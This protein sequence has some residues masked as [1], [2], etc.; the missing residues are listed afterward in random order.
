MFLQLGNN[1][2]VAFPV[3]AASWRH[4]CGVL[5]SAGAAYPVLCSPQWQGCGLGPQEEWAHH[6]SQWPQQQS[7]WRKGCICGY[8]AVAQTLE[9]SGFILGAVG[10]SSLGGIAS[11]HLF[12]FFP[13][14]NGERRSLTVLKIHALLHSV[15]V[16]NSFMRSLPASFGLRLL[17][18]VFFAVKRR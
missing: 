13:E 17:F 18:W 1:G 12:L 5:E 7:E 2:C 8:K 11:K 3:L 9:T 10:T 16:H 6:Q 14:W 4:Q 15:C